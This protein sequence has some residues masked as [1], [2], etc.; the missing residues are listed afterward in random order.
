MF[1]TEQDIFDSIFGILIQILHD[2]PLNGRQLDTRHLL[3]SS[4]VALLK[5]FLNQ[6]PSSPPTEGAD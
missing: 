2:R 5:L 3:R 6:V 1:V 4:A